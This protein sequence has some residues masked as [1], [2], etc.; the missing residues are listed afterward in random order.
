MEAQ[1]FKYKLDFY[2]QQSL[3]YLVTLII[4][5]GVRGS[6][7]EDK[8]EFVFRDPIFYVFIIFV[9]I[10]F[11][12]LGLNTLRDKRLL[13]TEHQLIFKTRFHEHIHSISEIEWMHISREK[14]V[15]TAGRRQVVVLKTK[16]RRR[17]FRIRIGRYERDRE[18]LL[19]MQRI[20]ERV[21][22]KMKRRFGNKF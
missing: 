9:C 11:V 14:S 12:T 7:I 5:I 4:Y 15:R 6:F 16:S 17:V 8:F 20:A 2:Y 1:T 21:P 10:S 19:E 22:R 18:L 3:V 13:I